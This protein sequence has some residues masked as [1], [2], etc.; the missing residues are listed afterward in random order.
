MSVTV[1]MTVRRH[2]SIYTVCID[3]WR[4]F[5]DNEFCP[6]VLLCEVKCLGDRLMSEKDKPGCKTSCWPLDRAIITDLQ[7]SVTSSFN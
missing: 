2:C 6:E 5:Y 7:E 1:V 3:D 4:T